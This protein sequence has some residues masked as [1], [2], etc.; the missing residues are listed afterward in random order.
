MIVGYVV[1]SNSFVYGV[2]V[3]TIGDAVEAGVD[4]GRDCEDCW[5]F[6]VSV[7]WMCGAEG[8]RDALMN[9]C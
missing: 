8:V 2:Y 7:R 6:D 5:S 4:A 9:D 3:V 1:C